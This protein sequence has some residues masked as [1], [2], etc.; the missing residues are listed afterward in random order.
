M[1]ITQE[2]KTKLVEK[3]PVYKQ[4]FA[5]EKNIKGRSCVKK[6]PTDSRDKAIEEGR[7]Y[8]YALNVDKCPRDDTRAAAIEEGQGC[9]Y[10]FNID[11]PNLK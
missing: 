6:S 5:E 1:Q 7:G 8:E 4:L 9:R 2:T 10:A 3:Y 11:I